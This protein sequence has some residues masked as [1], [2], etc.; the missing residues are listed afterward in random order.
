MT[1][2]GCGLQLVS[3]RQAEHTAKGLPGTLDPAALLDAML[4]RTADADVDIYDI[5]LLA[6]SETAALPEQPSKKRSRTPGTAP[7]LEARHAT[8]THP[9]EHIRG[10]RHGS[11]FDRPHD[12]C[13]VMGS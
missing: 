10:S 12:S 6:A 5:P 13:Q 2:L 11:C 3:R 7:A 8:W 4:R 1:L 9:T